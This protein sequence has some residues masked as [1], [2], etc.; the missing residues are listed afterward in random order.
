MAT[1]QPRHNKF[2]A[3]V[4]IPKPLREHHEGREFLYRTLSALDRRSAQ[5]EADA[6]EAGLRSEWLSMQSKG[7]TS[8]STLRTIYEEGRKAALAGQYL[9][10][11]DGEDDPIEVGIEFEIDKLDEEVGENELTEGQEARLAGL[12]DAL[13]IHQGK[14]PAP[15]PEME[16]SFSE[17]AAQYI[18]LWATQGGLKPSNTRQ[19]KEATFRLFSG[20]IK[21][22]PIREVRKAEAAGF[23]DE[24]RRLDPSW[25][26][27]PKA[28]KM[29]WKEI[30]KAF[31]GNDKGLSASTL[32]RH[33]RTLQELW[34][35]A[36]E[37][38]HCDGR[39]PFSGLTVKLKA[40]KNQLGY[41]PWT[42]EELNT[43]F[44]PPPARQDVTEVMVVALHTGMRLNEI[45]SLTLSQ[46][47]EEDGVHYIEVEDAKTE[48]GNRQVPIHSRIGWLAELEGKP[49][50]RVWPNFNQEGPSRNAGQDAS[51]EF[52]RFKLAKGFGERK[53]FHSFRKN[54]TQIMERKGVS[55][56]EWAQVLGHER[57]FTYSR[58][59]PHGITLE[60][61]AELIGIIEY[62]EV[63]LPELRG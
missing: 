58:Y 61:K 23:M 5:V 15:R 57:G 17:L 41:L 10:E 47:K 25:A 33:V 22:R 36:E 11:M 39:N 52:S 37:R 54:V 24:L 53:V 26:R 45:A 62:P 12:Q 43:L 59:S 63:E 6:W 20:Y 29:D 30:R 18:D 9:V 44:D 2:R 7:N 31:G 3:K 40:G 32:N 60:R 14:P 16:L 56:N 46:I 27:S 51:K 48:A 8:R 42:T 50:D 13:A 35:W 4:R 19:Q 28:K 38:E 49:Q 55:E 34:R 1:L 21:D